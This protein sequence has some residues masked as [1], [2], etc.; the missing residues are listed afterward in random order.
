MLKSRR[1][2]FILCRANP[3]YILLLLS[4]PYNKCHPH[5]STRKGRGKF[6]LSRANGRLQ[7]ACSGGVLDIPGSGTVHPT[8]GASVCLFWPTGNVHSSWR[9]YVCLFRHPQTAQQIIEDALT[10]HNHITTGFK[11]VDLAPDKVK[12]FLHIL[13][14]LFPFWIELQGFQEKDL[15]LSEIQPWHNFSPSER[16]TRWTHGFNRNRLV[17]D[18]C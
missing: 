17:R 13:V 16:Y 15:G 12:N 2:K 4:F 1:R 14:V 7:E 6:I 9:A 8:G 11:R 10:H 3:G 5:A 18:F